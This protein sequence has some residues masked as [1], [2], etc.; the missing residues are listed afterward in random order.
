M[1]Q[2]RQEWQVEEKVNLRLVEKVAQCK[3]RGS[4]V[5]TGLHWHKEHRWKGRKVAHLEREPF[6]GLEAFKQMHTAAKVV[7]NAPFVANDML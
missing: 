5:S 7:R 3:K 4:N 6:N 2:S 1:P